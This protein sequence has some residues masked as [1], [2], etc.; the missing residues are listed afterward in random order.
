[1]IN[2]VTLI[3]NVG[4]DPELRYTA[5]GTA[6]ANFSLATSRRFKDRDGT[7][8]DETEW[9]KLVAW[10]RTAEVIN[11]YAPKGKQ[12][13]IEGRLQ[14]RQWDDKEG[15][16]RYTTEIVV[17]HMKLLGGKSDGGEGGGSHDDPAYHS[18][19]DVAGGSQGGGDDW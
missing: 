18:G 10:G 7:Q 11:Q 6:V 15:N 9:H 13:Y 17:E 5:S 4:R 1:M 12:L 19:Q 2:K 16:T 8:R 3:G 14:T